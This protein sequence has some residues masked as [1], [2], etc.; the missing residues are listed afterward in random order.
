MLYNLNSFIMKKKIF[1]LLASLCFA[2]TLVFSVNTSEAQVEITD[3]IVVGAKQCVCKGSS[4]ESSAFI[5][6]RKKCGKEPCK[7][8]LDDSNVPGL[9]GSSACL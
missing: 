6:F 7:N 8:N 1:G 2:L 9:S 4:C 5:S 3:V